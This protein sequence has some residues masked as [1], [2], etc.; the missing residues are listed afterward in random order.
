MNFP[1]RMRS[2]NDPKSRLHNVF[3]S[4]LRQV[5]AIRVFHAMEL[6]KSGKTAQKSSKILDAIKLVL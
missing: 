2:I 6:T 3:L 5:K 1:D 4:S